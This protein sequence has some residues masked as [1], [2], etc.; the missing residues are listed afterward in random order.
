MST[1][2]AVNDPASAI[3]AK[4]FVSESFLPKLKIPIV[5]I[6]HKPVASVSP[7]PMLSRMPETSTKVLV[8]C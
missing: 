7:D 3:L 2:L 6:V 4:L 5:L 8:V 1:T